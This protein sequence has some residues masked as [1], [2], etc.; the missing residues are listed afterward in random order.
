ML[1]HSVSPPTLGMIWQ[2]RMVYRVG[3]FR[4]VVSLCHTSVDSTGLSLWLSST[5]ISGNSPC[6]RIGCTSSSPNKRLS[7]TCCAVVRFWLRSTSTLCSINAASNA[8]NVSAFIP[9]ARSSP[10]ISAPNV[11]PKR[12]T[13]NG[14]ASGGFRSEVSSWDVTLMFMI[15]PL[16]SRAPLCLMRRASANAHQTGN[17]L[18]IG[19][20][21]KSQHRLDDG[22]LLALW[23][24]SPR[25]LAE[26]FHD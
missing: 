9:V 18:A 11:A 17:L 12:S 13:S 24:G 5:R 20:L 6:G 8:L 7:A 15:G 22:L 21:L 4:N 10:W 23:H 19:E 25:E 3:H 1:A 14:A 2:R 26:L 16:C